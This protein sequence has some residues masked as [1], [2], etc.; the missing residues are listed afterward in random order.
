MADRGLVSD[1]GEEIIQTG[2]TT[3]RQ[4]LTEPENLIKTALAQTTGQKINPKEVEK[5]DQ[6]ALAK[7][8]QELHALVQQTTP[9]PS[10]KEEATPQHPQTQ[11]ASSLPQGKKDMLPPITPLSPET[12]KKRF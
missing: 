9:K 4:I 6:A 10:I 8:R 5:K 3:A 11:E 12:R 1:I 2:K 7:K